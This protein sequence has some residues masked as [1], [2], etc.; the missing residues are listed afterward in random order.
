M[1]SHH[2]T[3]DQFLAE[4][5]LNA[6]QLKRRTGIPIYRLR[7]IYKDGQFT[8]DELKKLIA[9][10]GVDA[11]V[12]MAYACQIG[13]FNQNGTGNSQTFVNNIIVIVM[14]RL[15]ITPGTARPRVRPTP[16]RPALIG[17]VQQH[18]LSRLP[19]SQVAPVGDSLSPIDRVY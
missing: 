6:Q 14:R 5:N 9:A 11:A 3:F 13:N 16:A 8:T 12:N 18:A 19:A 1:T 2:K 10:L 7:A 17:T 4:L 15:G